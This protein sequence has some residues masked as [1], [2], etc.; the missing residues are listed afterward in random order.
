MKKSILLVLLLTTALFCNANAQLA[1]KVNSDQMLERFLSYV[2]IE[3][4]SIDE[5]DMTSFPMSEGQRQIARH[6]YN[7]VKELAGN[8]V[9]VTL[10]D[11]YYVYIDIPSNIDRDV[12]SILLM[13]HMDV[14]PEVQ[15][16]GITPVVH[17]NYDGGDLHLPAGI[18][19]SPDSPQGAHLKGMKGKTIVTSDGSTLL[20]ADDKTGCAIL[21]SLIQE[22]AMNPDFE[23]GRVMIALSQNEDVGKAALRY[24]PTVFG[25]KPDIVVDVDGGT[26]GTYSVANF[27]AIGQTYY[28]KGNSV[29][30]SDGKIYG[31]ADALEA[32]SHFISL[33]PHEVNPASRE[34]LEGYIHCYT[35]SNPVGDDGKPIK[36][37]YVVKVRIRYFDQQE[38]AEFQ[39]IMADNLKRVQQD[40]PL[41]ESSLTD[42]E[43]Q[44]DNVAYTM[45][46]YL[47]DMI[48]TAA[49]DAGLDFSPRSS[50]GGSTSSMM[51]AAFPGVMPGGSCIYS[52]QQAEHSTSEWCCI[53]EMM[54]LVNLTENLITQIANMR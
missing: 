48:Q 12:P 7:E 29:H 49:R 31:Y 34:G 36:S 20:G 40:F 28:F 39:Q 44:Y 47:P 1:K 21:V 18:T 5:P 41:V 4:P 38:G 26:A 32:A 33:V 17:R 23:H 30:P 53:E 6:I 16:S 51:V 52:G 50:R 8:D 37:D 25:D 9:K 45:P 24:D 54:Q 15:G 43:M 13:A 27:S 42:N 14:T 11:D 35:I 22:M 46:A 3:S 19:L 10:S 2:R